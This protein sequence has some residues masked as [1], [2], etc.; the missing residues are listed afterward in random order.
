MI[1]AKILLIE[2]KKDIAEL[3]SRQFKL[4][5][6]EIKVAK[7][8]ISGLKMM[9]DEQFDL[10]LLN[11]MLP[12]MH[13]LELLKR[14]RLTNPDYKTPIVILSNNSEDNII[15]E[16]FSLGVKGYLIK[17]NHTPAQIIDYI[18]NMF[19]RKQDIILC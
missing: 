19:S 5:G 9:R 15:K 7:S 8:G 10:V 1:M 6:F 11:I 13:G 2:G 16:S 12:E 3:Y 17:A 18:R 14:L 4:A